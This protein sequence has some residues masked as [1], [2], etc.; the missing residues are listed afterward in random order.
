[1]DDTTTLVSELLNKLAEL[2]RK[3]C[4][5]RQ[6]MAVDFQ[7]YS[8]DLLRSAPE[9][10]SARVEEVLADELHNYP[11]LAP[12]FASADTASADPGRPPVAQWPRRGRASPPPVLPHTSGVPPNDSSPPDR[13]RDREFHGLFM[14]SYLPLLEVVQSSMPVTPPAIVSLPAVPREN[15]SNQGQEPSPLAQLDAILRR[16]NPVR[17]STEDTTSSITS[18]D[19]VSR[20]RRS[21]LRRSSSGSTKDAAQSPRRVRFDVEG[22]EVLPTVSPP[23]SPRIHDL[24]ISPLLEDQTAPI[25]NALNHEGYDE[26]SS[27]FGNSP[28]RPK[29]ISSTERLKAL[30]RSST[31]DT[32]QWT[33]VGDIHDEEEEEDGLVMSTSKRKSNVVAPDPAPFVPLAGLTDSHHGTVEPLRDPA[34]ANYDDQDISEPQDDGLGL[35]LLSSSKEKNSISSAQS[36]H[37]GVAEAGRDENS[38]SQQVPTSGTK[39]SIS[40]SSPPYSNA[41][42]LEEDMFSFDDEELGLDTRTA[43]TDAKYIDEDEP[44]AE[45]QADRPL[46]ANLEEEPVVSLY[47]TSPAISIAKPASFSSRQAGASVGSYKGKPF[48]IDVI[49]NEELHQKAA[50]M[51]NFESFVGS[52]DGRSGFDAS[53]GFRQAPYYSNGGSG[54]I[55]ERLMGKL[56]THRDP[57]NASK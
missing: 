37:N 51:G 20:A 5:Y 45:E 56:Q 25:H 47:S 57:D 18:D 3:V 54:S 24:P 12:G 26:E 4:D 2:D 27:V 53:D 39:T 9:H 8:H 46:A 49:R 52:V 14:P 32:S 43:D 28:P 15:Q 23:T 11:A 1:M 13:N 31:E 38:S 50:E 29:K 7:R 30:A 41:L 16:P 48:I 19:S 35:S 44:E 34:N 10:V 6:E 22:E 33:V 36:S 55:N 40:N 21:A 17:H 42:N